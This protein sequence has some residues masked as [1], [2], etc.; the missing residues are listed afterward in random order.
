[1][2]PFPPG[3]IG[4]HILYEISIDEENLYP[5]VSREGLF[6]NEEDLNGIAIFLALHCDARVLD[7][8]THKFPGG[9]YTGFLLLAESHLAIHTWPEKEYAAIDIFGCNPMFIDKVLRKFPRFLKGMLYKVDKQTVINREC[10][11]GLKK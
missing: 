5:N 7:I 10:N 8:K 11:F 6:K 1:M 3:V 4:Q 9:G 2:N